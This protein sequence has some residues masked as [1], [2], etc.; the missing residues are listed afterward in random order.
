MNTSAAEVT[1]SELSDVLGM[2][3]ELRPECLYA[4][5]DYADVL[6][7][8]QLLEVAFGTPVPVVVGSQQHAVVSTGATEYDVWV[9]DGKGITNHDEVTISG[10]ITMVAR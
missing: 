10:W 1:S 8:H 3:V 7:E 4:E 6:Y 9:Q 5:F 2:P